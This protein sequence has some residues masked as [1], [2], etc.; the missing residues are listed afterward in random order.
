M[1]KKLVKATTAAALVSTV[2]SPYATVMAQGTEVEN[3]SET[4][5]KEAASVEE[6][7]AELDAATERNKEALAAQQAALDE[8]NFAKAEREK[9][10]RKCRKQLQKQKPLR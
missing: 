2:V 6:A 8:L 5:I 3:Q 1:N 9:Q 7:K 4:A 10:P